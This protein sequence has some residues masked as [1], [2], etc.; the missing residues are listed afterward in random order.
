MKRYI[1]A[2]STNKQDLGFQLFSVAL[3][4]SEHLTKLYLFSDVDCRLHW[5]KEIWNFAHQLPKL[6]NSKKL[7]KS[8]FVFDKLSAYTDVSDSLIKSMCEEY[9]DYIPSSVD[10]N[11]L[12]TMLNQYFQWLAKELSTNGKVSSNQVY[13]KLEEIGF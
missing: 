10:A 1:Y 12:E 2:M 7:P 9:K 6:K 3:P 4:L 13:S 11:E 8:S 5:K